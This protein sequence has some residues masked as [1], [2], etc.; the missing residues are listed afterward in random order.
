[1]SLSF[2]EIQNILHDLAW[3]QGSVLREVYQPNGTDLILS[4]RATGGNTLLLVSVHPSFSRLHLLNRR[5]SNPARP[6]P[7]QM[8]CRK[9]LRG[10]LE[11][12]RQVEGDRVVRL[13]FAAES[14][15]TL[16]AELTGRHGNVFLLD[17]EE[18][19]L[20]SLRPMRHDRRNL[21]VGA[22]YVPLP[23]PS[24]P[25]RALDRFSTVDGSYQ[26]AVRLHYEHLAEKQALETLRGRLQASV[27][28]ELKRLR[29]R[30]RDLEADLQRAEEAEKYRRYGDVLQIHLREVPRG[31]SYVVLPDPFDDD[32]PLEIPLDPGLDPVG[33]MK[34][35]YRRYK[36]YDAS[37]PFVLS[38]LE[39]TEQRM[40]EL[41]SIGP[42]LD[43]ATDRET[44]ERLAARHHVP[45]S[46]APKARDGRQRGE[47]VRRPYHTYLARSGREIW[48]GRTSQ[49][50]DRLTFREA[51]GNDFWLHVRGRRGTHV[52]IPA[53]SGPPDLDTL[54]DA[55]TLALKHSGISPGD[56]VEVCYTRV[57]HVRKVPGRPGLV[58]FSQ[59]KSLLVDLDPERLAGLT[60]AEEEEFNSAPR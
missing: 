45:P 47:P 3:L 1:M 40:E 38:R 14:S 26:E 53:R 39:Q 19:V 46:P 15:H 57:K 41:M 43:Q 8:L 59:E 18:R 60:R 50:N 20:G 25:V 58:T 17:G 31:R 49:D 55:A 27:R 16:L 44:L 42:L 5:P 28:R 12:L 6:H 30:Q 4:L 9:V 7:F 24:G 51:R 32:R 2:L 54:L 33:N 29:R 48:V 22:P 11:D 56:R 34:R 13:R 52:V 37:I 36:K 21:A 23:P 10:R 35:L